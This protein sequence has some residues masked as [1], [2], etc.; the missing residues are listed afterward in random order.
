MFAGVVAL[1]AGVVALLTVVA[2]FTGVEVLLADALLV[3]QPLLFAGCSSPSG[4]VQPTAPTSNTM[5]PSFQCFIFLLLT[6]ATPPKILTAKN[7]STNDA[8]SYREVPTD[9]RVFMGCNA[10]LDVVACCGERSD[11]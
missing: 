7:M 11:T 2:L 1:F 6:L 8:L 4:S 3:T 5:A 10:T 9:A